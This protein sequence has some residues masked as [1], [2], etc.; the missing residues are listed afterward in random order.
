MEQK[1]K[2][3]L[4]KLLLLI[5]SDCKRLP[6]SEEYS[7][8][9]RQLIRSMSSSAANYN[10]GCRAKSKKDFVYKL[11][12]VIEELDESHF[13]IDILNSLPDNPEVF[14]NQLAEANELL[15]IMIASVKT[16]EVNQKSKIV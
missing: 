10:A 12:L 3:R 8:I 16:M 9:K 7:I 4:K 6:K 2:T 11:K 14:N 15:S 5:I 13:W 1:I